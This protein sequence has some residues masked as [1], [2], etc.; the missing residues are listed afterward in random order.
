MTA[1]WF[2]MSSSMVK[3]LVM[4]WHT[5][6]SEAN[7]PIHVCSKPNI[8]QKQTR[9]NY[10]RSEEQDR[11]L[12]FLQEL[13]APNIHSYNPAISP[14]AIRKAFLRSLPGCNWSK[15]AVGFPGLLCHYLP[16]KTS[17]GTSPDPRFSLQ[18]E[19]LL[20]GSHYPVPTP[21][22]SQRISSNPS[23]LSGISNESHN[24]PP[25]TLGMV[26]LPVKKLQFISTAHMH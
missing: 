7:G 17:E 3:M 20:W 18:N 13:Q 12:A 1:L 14:L 16:P 25:K 19:L 22:L 21:G 24:L 11:H 6:T 23:Y 8:S 2:L 5:G 26:I 15:V 10:T 4:T 9:C